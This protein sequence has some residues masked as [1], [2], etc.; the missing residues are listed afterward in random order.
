MLSRLTVWLTTV[1]IVLIFVAGVL[2]LTAS[3]L[4]HDSTFD[5]SSTTS[6]EMI[7]AGQAVDS[8]ADGVNFA[9]EL[10][11]YPGA[12]LAMASVVSFVRDVRREWR[13]AE[14]VATGPS[15]QA[16]LDALLVALAAIERRAKT[17]ELEFAQSES[18]R[19]ANDAL[20]SLTTTQVQAVRA[21]LAASGQ[22]V[23]QHGKTLAYIGY[24]LA[25]VFFIVGLVVTFVVS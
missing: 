11:L 16:N 24:A 20:V 17:A 21:E 2:V 8:L 12:V 23:D 15:L 7:A 3:H 25:V 22:T 13:R 1:A 14:S 9:S 19:A 5:V 18:Q 10:F 6:L 4:L